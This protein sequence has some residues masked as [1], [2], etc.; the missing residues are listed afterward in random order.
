MLIWICCWCWI[1]IWYWRWCQCRWWHAYFPR[2]TL[3]LLTLPVALHR[4][5][6]SADCLSQS[7]TG[8]T[9][10]STKMQL[11]K[12]CRIVQISSLILPSNGNTICRKATDKYCL[13]H[14]LK[15]TGRYN[16]YTQGYWNNDYA[17]QNSPVHGFTEL[18]ICSRPW[19]K[20]Q[21]RSWTYICLDQ[22]PQDGE[23]PIGQTSS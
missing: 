8:N 9:H 1:E 11:N 16:I 3:P 14:R 5:G 12:E 21:Q 15:G 7:Y 23:R 22:T 17:D 20:Q 4:G 6:L 13:Y 19:N 2:C 18:N 10:N